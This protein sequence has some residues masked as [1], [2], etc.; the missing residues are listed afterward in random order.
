[1]RKKKL[2]A[3]C[4]N[5]RITVA[6]KTKKKGF[7][8]AALFELCEENPSWEKA[9]SP[10]RQCPFSNFGLHRPVAIKLDTYTKTKTCIDFA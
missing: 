2:K 10:S 6:Y 9:V 1:M 5:I 3:G 4:V 7:V 8:F